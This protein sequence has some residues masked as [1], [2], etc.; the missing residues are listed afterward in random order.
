M[1]LTKWEPLRDLLTL[2]DRM[3]RLFDDSMRGIRP[4]ENALSSG[5]WSP[6][7]DIYETEGDVILK[8]ELPE[9]NQKDI[10]I[11][12]ENNTLTLKGERRFEKETKKENF[13]RIERAYGTFTRSFTLPNAID[14]EKIHADYKDGVLKITMPKREETKS[15]QIKV[16]VD[17]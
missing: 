13:H 17:S 3:N 14:Q 6:P 2:Q 16:A 4:E 10:D 8:A 12:V 7:V 5:I 1:T 11:Q 9:V 15:K